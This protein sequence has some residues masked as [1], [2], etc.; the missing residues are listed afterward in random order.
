MSLVGDWREHV[1][2]TCHRC[3]SPLA[4][5]EGP[6]CDTCLDADEVCPPGYDKYSD[7]RARDAGAFHDGVP[8]EGDPPPRPGRDLFA[9]DLETG[10]F[11]LLAGRS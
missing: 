8:R 11:L 2:A 1:C 3:K 9:V 6:I 7:F 5:L 4:T 10:R